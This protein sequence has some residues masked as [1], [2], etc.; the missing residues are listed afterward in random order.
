MTSLDIIHIIIELEA[1]QRCLCH[2]IFHRDTL[3]DQPCHR[4][5]IMRRA[6]DDNTLLLRLLISSSGTSAFWHTTR[7]LASISTA[8]A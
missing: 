2:K 3:V 4:K 6:D 1:G 7:Q 5:C 8:Q